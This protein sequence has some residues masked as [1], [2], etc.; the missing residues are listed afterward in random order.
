MIKNIQK[1]TIVGGGSA[2]WMSAAMMI[3]FFPN[4]NITVIESPDHPIVG[5]GES[6][7]L[8]IKNYCALLGLDEK[9]FMKHTDA[10]YKMSIKFTDFYERDDGG[11]HYPFGDP[12]YQGTVHE[13]QDW[14]VKKALYPDTPNNDFAKHYYPSAAL[15]E[16]NKFTENKEGKFGNY[17]PKYHAAYHF[18]ATKFGL[19]LR[20]K[21]CIPK[22]VTHVSA[23]VTDVITD[24]NGVKELILNNGS[25]VTSDLYLDCT[26][27]KSLLLGEALGTKFNSFSEML[28]NNR[29]WATRIAYKD[30][31]KELE[32]FTNSTAL[33]HGWVWNI[34]SWER[35][36]TGYVY[37]DKFINPEDAKE[38]FKQHLMSDKMICPRTRDEVDA[39][40][41]KDIPM[42][43]GIHDRIFVKNVCAIGLSAGFI[44]PLE[45]NGLFSVHEFLFRLVKIIMAG[46]INQFDIDCFNTACKGLFQ[47]FAEFV[48]M[49][50]AFSKRDDT[51]YWR[52]NNNRTYDKKM[53]DLI[54]SHTGVGFFEYADHKHFTAHINPGKG[55]VWIATGMNHPVLDTVDILNWAWGHNIDLHQEY[56]YALMHNDQNKILWNELAKLEL[57]LCD[58]LQKNIHS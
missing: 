29:A 3:K 38:E 55:Q 21:Y 9:D 35:L 27:F 12:Y 44:E 15:Y 28:P 16:Q 8:G 49:H 34:P 22:G 57:S 7:L 19:W 50:Y 39:L 41:F 53:I 48:A 4:Y 31:Q 1:I 51:E 33:G 36:G 23:T 10:S 14:F 47:N 24:E 5:V 46:S 40:E 56:D 30:K 42:R 43:V 17:N 20:D 11:F 25:T 32:P 58:Y 45:S 37:S 18:D 54:P 26:G 2:G 13:I 52:A 6:T